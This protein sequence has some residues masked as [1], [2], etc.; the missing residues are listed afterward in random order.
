MFFNENELS[1]EIVGAFKL[2]RTY[3]F[4]RTSKPR[5]YDS[6]S[7]RLSGSGDFETTATD[8]S[9]KRGDILYIPKSKEY[10]QKTD[11][12][13]IIAI[14]FINYS[15]NNKNDFEILSIDELEK[16]EEFFKEIYNHWK[17]KKSGYKYKCAAIFYELIYHLHNQEKNQGLNLSNHGES[18]SKAVDYIHSHFRSENI[19]IHKLSKMCYMSDAYFRKIFKQ[20]FDLSPKQYIINL[21]LELATQLL[22]SQFYS[23]SEITSKAGFSDSKYFSKIFKKHFGMSPREFQKNSEK[24]LNIQ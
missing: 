2:K 14:H 21:R 13:S 22:Q 9:V 8:F 20:N 5:N 15:Y 11:G 19:D 10:K 6:L 23:I 12:E 4:A 16:V 18:I 1:L 3:S 17:E 7:I 24:G